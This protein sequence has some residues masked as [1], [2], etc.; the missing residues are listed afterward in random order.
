M[1]PYRIACGREFVRLSR[2]YMVIL[3][4][5]VRQKQGHRSVRGDRKDINVAV[6]VCLIE[7]LCLF[8]LFENALRKRDLQGYALTFF[9]I[10]RLHKNFELDP[11]KVPVLFIPAFLNDLRL[12]DL[13]SHRGI[14]QVFGNLIVR[15]QGMRLDKGPHGFFHRLVLG[16]TPGAR[17]YLLGRIHLAQMGLARRF[18]KDRLPRWL[19]RSIRHR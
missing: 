15:N 7:D 6:V 18:D 12:L 17:H 4:H 1:E 19:F 2:C 3:I 14:H 9:R 13:P 11:V 10:D 5:G 16:V 8:A